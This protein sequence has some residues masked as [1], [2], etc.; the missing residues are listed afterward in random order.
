[1]RAGERLRVLKLGLLELPHGACSGSGL[2]ED[3]EISKDLFWG[4]KHRCQPACRV[5]SL[6]TPLCGSGRKGSH[7]KQSC[8][9]PLRAQCQDRAHSS[10]QYHTSP[11]QLHLSSIN[12]SQRGFPSCACTRW[13]IPEGAE[14]MDPAT[15]GTSPAT[16]HFS[17]ANLSQGQTPPRSTVEP[18]GTPTAEKV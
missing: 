7:K 3:F 2:L 16:A 6:Q 5:P 8:L 4:S 1:M 14:S 18:P 10:Q 17:P 13:N 15:A 9:S 12:L 11:E